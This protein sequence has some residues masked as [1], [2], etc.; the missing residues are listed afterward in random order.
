MF[1][2]IIVEVIICLSHVCH[3]FLHARLIQLSNT[4]LFYEVIFLL[5]S[6]SQETKS[7]E[8]TK[9]PQKNKLNKRIKKQVI[10]DKVILKLTIS[11][12]VLLIEKKKKSYSWRMKI[13]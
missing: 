6:F 1:F 9:S 4:V 11:N 8:K 12:M 10:D 3:I 7:P 5:F 13:V 2:T